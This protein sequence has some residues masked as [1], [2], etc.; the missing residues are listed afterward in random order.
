MQHATAPLSHRPLARRVRLAL[1]AAVIAAAAL[2]AVPANAQFGG[3]ASFAG[4]F[5]PDIMQRDLPLMVQT[6]GLED[7]Q[8]PI[9]ETL[10]D[11]YISNFN[12]GVEAAKER[13][14]NASAEGA[15]AAP[16]NGDAI[17]QKVMEQLSSWRNE[18]DRML[19]KFVADLRSQLG[20]QQMER[21]PVFERALRR[22]RDLPDGD[23]SGESVNLWSILAH[24]Q[25]GAGDQENIRPALQAYE[26]ALDTALVTRTRK[27]AELENE[28]RDAML[29]M[30]YERGA[31]VQD[32]IMA[33]R[34]QVRAA[35]DAGIDS[36]A[37]ALGARG[38]E[39]RRMALEAGYPDAYR[40]HPLFQLFDTVSKLDTLTP[41]QLQQIDALRTDFD[42]ACVEMSSRFY[43]MLRAEEPKEPRR[44]VQAML[45]RRAGE[46]RSAPSTPQ[47][48]NQADPIV[49]LR[50]ERDRMGEPYREKL[51][52][53]LTPEQQ[54][55]LPGVEKYEDAKR[56]PKD[57]N[58][59]AAGSETGD[60]KPEDPQD[61][62]RRDEKR[63]AAGGKRD[64]RQLSGAGKGTRDPG[65]TP[66]PN[67]EK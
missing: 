65:A 66:L 37:A 23:I 19:E 64:G 2:A 22:E 3:R 50:A 62:K 34:V 25:L 31:S 32:R 63:A 61:A 9:I 55:Q 20:D 15:K 1:G 27:M 21:W 26:V 58:A 54:A 18:K 59:K 30:D 16:G 49:K 29:T 42:A 24:M 7:W 53:I 28:L 52:A 8:R 48:S 10:L 40:K 17:L 60:E 44:R 33:L 39:F 56:Q 67:A 11:D 51:M 35:N 41:E 5:Q 6:L 14:K 57:P 36:I 12:A 45:D 43:E 38:D 46:T 47:G 13:M 4:A